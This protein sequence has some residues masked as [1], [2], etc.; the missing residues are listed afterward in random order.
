LL[1]I[2]IGKAHI[3]T[4]ILMAVGSAFRRLG[5]IGSRHLALL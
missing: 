1:M 3:A 2:S 4:D 5:S